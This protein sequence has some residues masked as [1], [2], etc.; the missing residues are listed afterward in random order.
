MLAGYGSKLSRKQLRETSVIIV[1]GTGQLTSKLLKKTCLADADIVSFI[2]SN[3]IH[4]GELW[5]GKPVVSPRSLV[6]SSASLL[7]ASTI[8]QDDIVAVIGEM[9]LQNELVLL[10]PAA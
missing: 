8:H 4:H 7:I 5:M 9:G 1:W 2:D 10:R 3:P 6:D